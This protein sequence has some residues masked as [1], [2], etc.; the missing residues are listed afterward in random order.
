M[1]AYKALERRFSRLSGLGHALS[2]LSWDRQVVMPP[3]ANAGRGEALGELEVMAHELLTDPAVA[4]L[5][6][7]AGEEALAEPWERANLEEMKRAHVRAVAVPGELVGA[8]ARATSASEM[9]WRTARPAGDFKALE[10]ELTEVVRLTR[11][12]ARAK[13]G[14]LGLSPYDAC[15]DDFQPGIHGDRIAPVFERLATEL[16]PRIERFLAEQR[17][18]VKPTKRFAA[19]EQRGIA[20]ALMERLGFDFERGRLDESAHPFCGGNPDDIRMTTRWDESDVASGLMGVLHETGHALYEAGLPAEWRQQPVGRSGGMTLHESQSL[21]VEMQACRSP[22]FIWFL[23]E[24]LREAFGDEPALAPENLEALYHHVERGLIRVD[25]DEATY[26]LHI[27]L[28]WRLERAMIEGE[29]EVAD[30]PDAWNEGMRELLGVTPPDHATGCLQDIHWPAGAF[31]YFPSYSLGAL[32]AAQ[33]FKAAEAA[34]PELD[35]RLRRGDF[36]PLLDWLRTHV[37]H[38]ARSVAFEPL[39]EDATGAPLGTDAFLAHLDGRYP[40]R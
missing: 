8:L 33:L 22:A 15:L 2:V 10:P 1:S 32:L 35:G 28:R 20:T 30:L 27:I 6:E 21:I 14:A 38:R 11:E 23:G 17:Q 4:E 34:I 13:G 29:L 31:G 40:A 3:G 39:V 24:R 5:V 18:P 26:P 36:R 16:P 25:A 19:L 7:A 12:V 37:H 9:T